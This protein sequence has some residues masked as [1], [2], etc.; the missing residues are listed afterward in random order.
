[1]GWVKDSDRVYDD[2]VLWEADKDGVLLWSVAMREAAAKENGAGSDGVLSPKDIHAAM[3]KFKTPI[4]RTTP[5]LLVTLGL[6]HDGD[7]L[8]RCPECRE[9]SGG[10]LA[11]PQHRY[12][13]G[14][15]AH[16]LD[17]KG[18]GDKVHR[19]L[20]QARSWL[21]GT[22][23]G[24]TRTATV[25][26][27][28]A[29]ECQYCGIFTRWEGR[30]PNDQRSKDLGE[31][32]HVNPF[33]DGDALNATGNLVVACK[34]CNGG[35]KGKGQRTPAQWAAEGGRLL[36]RPIDRSTDPTWVDRRST[37]DPIDD[38]PPDDGDPIA[39][40][41][42]VTRDSGPGTDPTRSDPGSGHTDQGP[43]RD[44]GPGHLEGAST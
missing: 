15:K 18:H 26:R 40:F 12:I 13:H 30:K 28:D 38:R 10:T 11:S 32:D 37:A 33:L 6:W 7:T 2:D 3:V 36:R 31:I 20:E 41:P 8:K 24:K 42:R 27:R 16:A 1:M 29:D 21:R 44:P 23:E 17:A 9:L 25:R 5:T 35:A 14:W 19:T 34:D 43:N 4:K 22:T 39:G